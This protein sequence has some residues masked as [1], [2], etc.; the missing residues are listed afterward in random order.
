MGRSPLGVWGALEAPRGRR[1]GRSARG[2]EEDEEER[3]G[4]GAR[5][6]HPPLPAYGRGRR[7]ARA[8]RRAGAVYTSVLIVSRDIFSKVNT[9]LLKERLMYNLHHELF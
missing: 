6:M 4:E 8:E 3:R 9:Y 7:G 2:E 1:D 5:F